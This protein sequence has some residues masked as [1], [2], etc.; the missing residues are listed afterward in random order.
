MPEDPKR[1]GVRRRLR[2]EYGIEASVGGFGDDG[3]FLRL[4]HA[5]YTTDEDIK[6]VEEAI[7]E[8]AGL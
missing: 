3:G 1:P 2:E 8:M 6:R 7:C 4:S 5:C